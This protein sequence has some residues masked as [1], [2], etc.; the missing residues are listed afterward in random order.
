MGRPLISQR[1]G[2]GSPSFTAPSHRFKAEVCYK[3]DTKDVQTAQVIAIVDDPGRTAVLVLLK[4]PDAEI[5]LPAAEGLKVGDSIQ[6]GENAELRIG[7]MLPLEKIPEGYPIFNVE[8]R[9]GNG[10]DL[11]RA[12][13]SVCFIVS[14]TSSEITVKLPSGKMRKLPTNC[15]A[16]IGNAA[17]GGRTKKPMLKA[18]VQRFKREARGQLFPIVRGV[19]QNPVEH[20]FGGKEHHGAITPKGKGAPPGVHVGSFGASR[21][22][23]RKR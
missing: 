2:K 14:K 3:N 21:T 5:L 13:G 8:S 15:R 16:T 9:A 4:F 11:A 18:S 17:G 19:H 20:P 10:G 23:R 1:R 6:Q 7:N 12:S 22:G